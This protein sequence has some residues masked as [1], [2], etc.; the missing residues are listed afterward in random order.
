MMYRICLLVSILLL[1]GCSNLLFVPTKPFPLTPDGAGLLYE[2]QYIET[3]DGL[4]LHGW[5]IFA[6]EKSA[7]NILF[8]HGPANT[9]PQSY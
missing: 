5:K 1:S 2:D 3:E 7:G 4:K 8:F 6:D 9:S